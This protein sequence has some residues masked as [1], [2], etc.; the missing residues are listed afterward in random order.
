M[1]RIIVCLKQSVD[2]TQLKVDPISR[3]PA[4]AEAPRR[5]SD[6][7]KNALE[8]AVRIKEKLGGEVV[9]LTVSTEDARSSLREALAMGAD[10]AYLVMDPSFQGSDALATSHILAK[11]LTKIGSFDLMLC[12]EASIDG[13]SAQVGPRLAELLGVPAITYVQ[14]LT[15][16]GGVIM[17]ERALEDCVE[18]VRAKLPALVTVTKGINT[19]RTPSLLAITKA[20]RKELVV[21]NVDDLG[22]TRESVGTSGSSI[23]ILD[24][25]A[26]KVERKRIKIEGE[27]PR[28]V[29]EKLARALLQEGVITRR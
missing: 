23:Q 18:V 22:L 1:R 19:P 12:G 17:A 26:P 20:M 27:T 13:F 24:V 9:A 16:E 11:A 8:E 21:W 10:K 5:I 7:D 25:A 4:V 14:K 29:A 2:V 6:F 28:E 3:R 15:I